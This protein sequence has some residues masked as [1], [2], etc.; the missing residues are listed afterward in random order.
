MLVLGTVN[1]HKG[2]GHPSWRQELFILVI[3]QI[4]SDSRSQASSLVQIIL[5]TDSSLLNTWQFSTYQTARGMV[6]T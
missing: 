5:K 6:Q 4:Q 3:K 1:A 2:N